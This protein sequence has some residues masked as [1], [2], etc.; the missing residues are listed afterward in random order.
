MNERRGLLGLAGELLFSKVGILGLTLAAAYWGYTH[1]QTIRRVEY[2]TTKRNVQVEQGY[3]PDPAGLSIETVINAAGRQEVYLFHK[4]SEAKIP[5]YGDLLPEN[6]RLLDSLV[7]RARK[8]QI[9]PEE[10]TYMLKAT[11]ELEAILYDQALK[12]GKR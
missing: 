7:A 1:Y 8:N 9:A 6:K 11:N 5:V 10:R 4:E 3:F 12:D 2:N